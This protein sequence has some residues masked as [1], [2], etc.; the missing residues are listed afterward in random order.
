MDDWLTESATQ[1]AGRIRR[2]EV[3][4]E[5]VVS[6]HIDRA[7]QTRVALGAIASDRFDEAMREARAADAQIARDPSASLP[8]LLG[9]PCSIKECFALTGMPQSAGL[10]ARRDYRAPRDAVTV[11]RLRAAGAIPIGVTNTSELCMWMESTNRLYGRTNNAYD[12]GRTAGGSSGGEGAIVGAGA[13][14][15]GLG[16]DVGG[17]IRMPAFFNGVFGHKPTPGLISNDGQFPTAHGDAQRYLCSGPITRRAEDLWPLLKILAG[18]DAPGDPD[19]VEL[20]GLVV[21]D[22]A[23]NGRLGVSREVRAA[24]VSAAHALARKGV[25]VRAFSSPRLRHSLEMWS[26]LM[27][28]AGGPTFAE[29]LGEGRAL[30][31]ARELGLWALGRSQHTFIAIAL[32]LVEKLP[33]LKGDQ[34]RRFVDMAREL[35]VELTTAMGEGGALLFP[36]YPTTAPRHNAPMLLPV[37]WMYTAIFNVLEMPVT[38]VPVGLGAGGLPLGVQVA[39]SP[40]RDDVTVALAIALERELGG[41]VS[42]GKTACARPPFGD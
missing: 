38:Q 37:Q 34:A 39:S 31:A 22:I 9:V 3:S 33:A 11:A 36:P 29:L 23:E 15:F 5:A 18:G 35:R 14:P 26:V 25:N 27:S 6:A 20:R 4:S 28:E 42:P 41:W 19:R 8:P 32:A 1:L 13:A 40:G 16:S 2:R 30:P 10:V 24:Q 7:K 17:S 21:L 12:V